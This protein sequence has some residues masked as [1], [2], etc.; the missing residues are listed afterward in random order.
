MRYASSLWLVCRNRLESS[1]RPQQN[2]E[3]KA[4]MEKESGNRRLRIC[5]KSAHEIPKGWFN[6]NWSCGKH[7]T[8]WTSVL[9][10]S[11]YTSSF[12]LDGEFL[13]AGA[14]LGPKAATC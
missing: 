11:G 3:L 12:S 8:Y 2:Q 5:R 14:S 10:V 9:Y 13:D 1:L 6:D 7:T 4:E